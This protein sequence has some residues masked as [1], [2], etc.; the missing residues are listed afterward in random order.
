MGECD[1]MR[2]TKAFVAK[3]IG[4]R[5]CVHINKK[6]CFGYSRIVDSNEYSIYERPIKSDKVVAAY[7]DTIVKQRGGRMLIFIPDARIPYLNYHIKLNEHVFP[8]LYKNSKIAQCLLLPY[9]RRVKQDMYV[10]DTR[11][12]VFTDRG[13][14]FHNNPSRAIDYEGMSFSDDIKRF[15]ESVVWDTPGRK[16]PTRSCN[17][18]ECESYYPGLPDYCYSYSPKINTDPTFHDRYKNGGFGKSKKI[19]VN[20]KEMECAR[21]YKHAR[22]EE[23][24]PFLF[25]GTGERSDKIN[26]IGTYRSNVASGVRICIFASSDGGREWFCKY[27]FSDVGEYEFQQGY[28]NAW[29][30]NFGNKIALGVEYNCSDCDVSVYKRDIVFPSVEDGGIE[31]VFSWEMKAKVS[32]ICGVEGTILHTHTPHGL[33][34]GNIIAL[35]S[36]RVLSNGLDWM[37]CANV[38]EYGTIGGTQFKVRVENDYCFEIYELTSSYVPTLPC[39]H[40]HHISTMKD[41][42]IVG[43]GEIYPN[44][45]LLYVQQRMADT[46]SVINASDTLT[47]SRINT[48]QD[49]VQRTMGMLIKDT[50]NAEVIFA[51][52][53]DTLQR[54]SLNSTSLKNISRGSIGIYIGKLKDIDNRNKFECIYDAME[55]CYFFQQ[56][57][58][59]LIFAGQR[60]ELGI[61]VDSHLE[62]WHRERIGR[63]IM[64]YMGSYH[65]CYFFNDYII[66]RK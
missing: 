54:D 2:I 1:E 12:C 25:I 66:V 56:I 50:L 64:Y 47:I 16:Y 34:N 31:T 52:D 30:T 13:Q 9:L 44:G 60:G 46:Y 5:R 11:L 41:G 48:T 45:W 14:I 17:P 32:K 59:M 62:Q 51:S 10:K 39:R 33:K 63:F 37:R 49:S 38:T 27:E 3:V 29:G 20:N 8:G 18:D 4:S 22:T 57:G 43:T 19:I 21:F 15:E 28:S 65:S 7:G 35:Q 58:D 36:S 42:W 40:I 6:H 24:N 55:P 23:A 61:C 53:H 26:L